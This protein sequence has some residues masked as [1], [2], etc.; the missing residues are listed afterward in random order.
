[1]RAVV[2]SDRRRWLQLAL[3]GAA[4]LCLPR[5]GTARA[6]LKDYPFS[7]GVASGSARADSVVLWTRLLRGSSFALAPAAGAFAV[8]WEV[9][10]DEG[11]RH[12]VRHGRAQAEPELAHSVH[13][14]VD[15]LQPDRWYF[16]RFMLGE[17]VSPV[18]RTRTL[19]LPDAVVT[20][21][22]IA[23]ASCQKWEDGYFSA[24]RHMRDERLD[25]V[26]FLGD[27]IYEYPGNRSGLRSPGG[28]WVLDLEGY[29]RRYAVYKGDPDLQAMHQACPWWMT[30]DDHEVQ[31]DYA[32]EHAGY[33]G[34]GDPSVPAAFAARRQAAYQAYYEHMPLRASTLRAAFGGPG[35]GRVRIHDRVQFG[36]LASVHL[37]DARQYKDPQVCTRDGRAGAGTIDPAACAR[38]AE[39]GRSMLGMAQEHWLDASLADRHTGQTRWNLLAQQTVFGQRDFRPG[40]GRILVNDGWDGYPAARRRL[41]DSL[42]Q[43]QVPNPVFLGGDVHANWVGHVLADHDRADSPTVAV[44]FCGT[45]ITSRGGGNGRLAALLAENPHCV[46]ADGVQHGY[47]IAELTAAGLQADLRIVSDVRKPDASISTL[48]TFTVEPGRPRISRS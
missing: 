1:M 20:R 7:L 42:R 43:H 22:R 13:A 15:G 16:Y 9:A 2:L 27:Y 23:Y 41:T 6:P 4:G 44:E 14:E 30:W 28:G 32:G 5:V 21:L 19:P 18:G 40:P 8:A 47:G 37:L 39:P 38:W 17:A 24:W 25:A 34:P 33:G 48:A 31:N 3:A 29:R 12:I 26:L 46:F 35:A 36:R 10:D 11:F 45:S